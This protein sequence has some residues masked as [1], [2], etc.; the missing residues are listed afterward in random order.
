MDAVAKEVATVRSANMVLLGAAARFIDL[1]AEKIEGG[2]RTVF[3]RKG[4]KL[5]E[6]NIAAF[7]A[8]YERAEGLIS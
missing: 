1:P 5:V 7:R 8:G 4:E 6:Q 2:I 3:S